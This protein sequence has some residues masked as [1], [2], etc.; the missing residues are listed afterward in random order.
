MS[1]RFYSMLCMSYACGDPPSLFTVVSSVLFFLIRRSRASRSLCCEHGTF[2]R[3]HSHRH[4]E[5]G[6]LGNRIR[7]FSALSR[8]PVPPH[9]IMPRAKSA[10]LNH[11][12]G[13][14]V[15]AVESKFRERANKRKAST[16]V[17]QTDSSSEG[18]SHSEAR[19]DPQARNAESE[20]EQASDSSDS[21]SD[22]VGRSVF[23]QSDSSESE[24]DSSGS[25]QSDQRSEEEEEEDSDDLAPQRTA[26]EALE[27]ARQKRAGQSAH[28]RIVTENTRT[29]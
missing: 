10:K 12:A 27:H 13:V 4:C 3:A 14:N 29:V 11:R 23:S 16:M 9:P 19:A 17:G 7:F 21:E 28:V 15:S 6:K 25:N 22:R 8:C 18:E 2:R 1:I 26:K 24:S 5:A 20:E